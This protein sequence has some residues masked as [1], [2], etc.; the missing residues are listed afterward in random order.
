VILPATIRTVLTLATVKSWSLRQLDVK[1]AFLH[2]YLDTTVFMDQP[3]GFEDS[4]LPHHVC[5]LQH[6][7]YG[8]K[9]AP[10]AWFDRFSTFLIDYG[11]L[12]SSAD[13]SL[14]VF[15]TGKHTLILLVYVDDIILTGSCS[16]LRADFVSQLS[17]Q[18][19]IKD[20]D[21]LNYFLGVQVQRFFGGIFLSQSKYMSD[22]L[23]HTTMLN[24]KPVATPMAS[25]QP[26]VADPDSPYKDVTEYRQIVSTL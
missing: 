12:C 5:K 15:N 11:F 26:F 21:P 19:S 18:F 17:A 4:T 9:Q 1:N 7:L 6:A 25:K 8:L 16:T 2:G 10:R 20:L 3:P 14:F 23:N 13:S 24:C 22:L